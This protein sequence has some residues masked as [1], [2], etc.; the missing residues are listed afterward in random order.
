MI[1]Y[2]YVHSAIDSQSQ[3]AHYEVLPDERK[4]AAAGLL[5]RANVFFAAHAKPS[6]AS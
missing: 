2:S 1:G 5:Q 4:E 6:D 3:L